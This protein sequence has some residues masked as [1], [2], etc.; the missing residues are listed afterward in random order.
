MKAKPLVEDLGF[1]Q[2]AESLNG[3]LA[4]LAFTIALVIEMLTG[5]GFLAFLQ[6]I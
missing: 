4:M 3:R 1:T 6:I 2:A 5:K